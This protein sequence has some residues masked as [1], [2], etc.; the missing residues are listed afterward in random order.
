MIYGRV[1]QNCEAI[2]SIAVG[3]DNSKK[4]MVKVL[5]DTGF[6]GFL[7]LPNSIINSLD[8]PWSFR[9]MAT[10]GDGSQSDFR[11]VHSNGYLGW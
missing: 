4:Q 7:S 8:L 3:Y 11:Y 10:L 1:N 2:L 5:I 6:T 9:D